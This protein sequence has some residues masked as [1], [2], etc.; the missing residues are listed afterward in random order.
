MKRRVNEGLKTD[1]SRSEAR[2]IDIT[3]GLYLIGS[4]CQRHIGM[5]TAAKA[6]YMAKNTPVNRNCSFIRALNVLGRT[7]CED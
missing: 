3:S 1:V 6:K 5:Y 7:M 4:F 2:I